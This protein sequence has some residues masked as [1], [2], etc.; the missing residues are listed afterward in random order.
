[1][2]TVKIIYTVRFSVLVEDDDEDK[3][4]KEEMIH[5]ALRIAGATL[6]EQNIEEEEYD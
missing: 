3:A 6:I 1:V 2:T 5:S 4:D